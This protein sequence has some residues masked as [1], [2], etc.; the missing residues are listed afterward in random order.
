MY[1]RFR[2]LLLAASLVGMT[3]LTGCSMFAPETVTL[4]RGET[5]RLSSGLVVAYR[6]Y[7]D[8]S[9][10]GIIAVNIAGQPTKVYKKLENGDAIQYKAGTDGTYSIQV[11]M[12][13]NYCGQFR[14]TR[15]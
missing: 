13:S 10:K 3:F 15:I 7:H 14:I 2:Y 4:L 9:D 1:R 8:P 12:A 11:M 5:A 6:D